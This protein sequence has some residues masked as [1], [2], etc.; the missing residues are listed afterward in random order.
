MQ[1]CMA[2]LIELAQKALQKRPPDHPRMRP[3]AP[4]STD[5]VANILDW[6]APEFV[7]E[8][9]SKGL[10]GK[11][12]EAFVAKRVKQAREEAQKMFP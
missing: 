4:L 5:H 6:A 11:K 12:L 10:T 2:I 9:R 1:F 3:N 7:L 8:G